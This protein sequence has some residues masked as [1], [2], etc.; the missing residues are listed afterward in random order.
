MTYE[1]T[2]YQTQ[3][4]CTYYQNQNQDNGTL[5]THCRYSYFWSRLEWIK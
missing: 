4:Q 1:Y 3:S 5:T 2:G